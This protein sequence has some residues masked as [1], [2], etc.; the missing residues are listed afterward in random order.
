MTP[1]ATM[2]LQL[3]AGFTLVQAAEQLDYIAAMGISHLYLSPITC[4]RKGSTHGYDVTDPT[5][6]DPEL[7]G[8]DALHAL[9]MAARARGMGLFVDLVPNHMAAHSDNPWWHSVLR[10]GRASPYADW[11]DIQW[12]GGPA[13]RQ[14]KVLLPVL[15]EPYAS[16]IRNGLVRLAHGDEQFHIDVQGLRLPVAAESLLP[17][18]HF[19]V[20]E[21]LAAHEPSTAA[22]RQALH[23]LLERQHYRL[24]W[25]QCAGEQINWRRFFEVSDLVGLRVE[26]DDVFSAVHAL[27]LRLFEQGVIDGVRVD[28]V[29]GLA[30]PLAYCRRLSQALHGRAGRRPETLAGTPPWRLVEKILAHDE[31]LDE[32]WAVDGTTGYDFMDRV[33]GVLHDPDG[34]APLTACW[35]RLARDARPVHAWRRAAR[36]RM[37]SHHFCAERDALL[38]LLGALTDVDLQTHDVTRRSLG[39]ALD[40]LLIEFEVY[41]TYASLDERTAHDTT[42]LKRARDRARAWLLEDHDLAG[43]RALGFVSDCLL[44]RTK[45]LTETSVPAAPRLN[46][47]H[48]HDL[49]M[50]VLGE[51]ALQSGKRAQ[52]ALALQ[53]FQQLTP[54]LAAKALED[55]VFYR[56]GRLLSRNDVGSDPACFSVSP[57]D[58]HAWNVHRARHTPR[59]MN[60]TATHDHKRGEDVRARLAVISEVPEVWDDVSTRCLAAMGQQA[61]INYGVPASQCY[62]LLQTIVGAWPPDLQTTDEAGMAHYMDRLQQ[63]QQKALREA[64]QESS[65]LCPDDAVEQGYADRIEFLL[66]DPES[67]SCRLLSGFAAA[68]APAGAL[69]SLAMA[70]LRCTLPGIPDLYQG[71]ELWDF[72]LVDPDNRRPVDFALRQTLLHDFVTNGLYDALNHGHG[73][74]HSAGPNNKPDV[75]VNNGLDDE[76]GD[77]MPL[78]LAGWQDGAVKQAVIMR[79]L[80]WRGR[81]PD[82]FDQGSYEPLPVQGKLADHLFAFMRRTPTHA[83]IVLVSRLGCKALRTTNG[84]VEPFLDRPLIPARLWQDTQI[85]L[86]HGIQHGQWYDVLTGARREAAGSSL[87][88]GGVLTCLPVAVLVAPG[89]DL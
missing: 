89:P 39:R 38:A 14:G 11:F 41:R 43:A 19:S 84:R 2:R 31:R 8:E 18:G 34:E 16:A 23:G 4:A 47:A 1:R 77:T 21:H 69:N 67:E 15:A 55:T 32:R 22:G 74:G 73:G 85:K 51:A 44:G 9:A 66:C 33:T 59:T 30:Q 83:M 58:F 56:Y 35:H 57:D 27:P 62:M 7:G 75:V 53:R 61:T 37:V 25:W 64:K 86:P 76:G 63:W 52:L 42:W 5:R 65:W 46:D 70:V 17:A 3:H 40:R 13:E 48:Y 29:D 87:Q 24:A 79:C 68:L 54:P 45:K 60:A 82:L 6:V 36:A 78:L 49:A 10:E 72:S 71:T 50:T 81:Q 88:V 80:Q 28:H 26:R 12:D 20:D